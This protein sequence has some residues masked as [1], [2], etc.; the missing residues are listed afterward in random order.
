MISDS[1]LF[2]ATKTRDNIITQFIY[3]GFD[4]FRRASLRRIKRKILLPQY[5]GIP[6]VLPSTHKDG[7][8]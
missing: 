8:H 2:K 4:N 5:A 6:G 7:T 3:T 1:Y